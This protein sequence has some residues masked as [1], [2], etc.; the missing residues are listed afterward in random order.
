M[1][2]HCNELVAQ[3]G[4]AVRVGERSFRPHETIFLVEVASYQ[5]GQ[6]L[7]RSL[8]VG[9]VEAG[10]CRIN[11]AE[12]AEEASVRPMDGN[13]RITLKPV[14][15]RRVMRGVNRVLARMRKYHRRRR[16]PDLIADGCLEHQL[17]TGN[18]PK[19]QGVERGAGGPG[20]LGHAGN[21]R[22]A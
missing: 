12:C 18:K 22:E 6:Q 13:G 1:T 11:R 7:H 19:P 9:H 17:A 15:P 10:R 21:C 20:G 14:D 16:L 3:V 5:I 2:Q 4:D 8:H